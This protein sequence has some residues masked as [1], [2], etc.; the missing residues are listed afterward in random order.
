MKI[1][2]FS[3]N[4]HS[5]QLFRICHFFTYSKSMHFGPRRQINKSCKS[6]WCFEGWKWLCCSIFH[7]SRGQNQPVSSS[8]QSEDCSQPAG[9]HQQTCK[10]FSFINLHH[11]PFQDVASSYALG[12]TALITV[13]FLVLKH[14]L[15]YIEVHS[16]IKILYNTCQ[17]VQAFFTQSQNVRI[18]FCFKIMLPLHCR[19]VSITLGNIFYEWSV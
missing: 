14:Y 18:L 17:W 15:N 13:H 12:I 9:H 10:T 2:S 6:Y 5:Y 3:P 8:S 1:F 4:K 7:K 11:W 16:N 19:I